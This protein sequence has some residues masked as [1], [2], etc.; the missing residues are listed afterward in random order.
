[1]TDVLEILGR[2]GTALVS[3]GLDV[4]G[5]A[6]K[7]V[8]P[9]IRQLT[10]TRRFAGRA[11]TIL[12]EPNETYVPP[13]RVTEIEQK[14]I[15]RIEKL[16]AMIQPGDVIVSGFTRPSPPIGIVGELFSTLY[17]HLGVQAVVTEGYVRDVQAVSELGF[18]LVAS[19]TTP[20]NG[21]G[22]QTVRGVQQPVTVGHVAVANGDLV[23]GDADG[24][25]VV[26]QDAPL[27]DLCAWLEEHDERDRKT[28]ELIG[29]TG[30]LSSAY[31]KLG[32]I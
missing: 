22:R 17:K 28:L 14:T 8:P 3:D 11:R 12:L 1:M 23:I 24:T 18:T 15:E 6:G 29:E 32:R 25:V 19:G 13:P 16:E 4:F 30:R 20:L 7:V 31:R 27:A 21:V 9:H 5:I 26:P 2:V 10:T